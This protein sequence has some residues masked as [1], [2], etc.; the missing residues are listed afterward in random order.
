MTRLYD[1]AEKGD[2]ELV[3]KYLA[4]G[5]DPN[6]VTDILGS[7]EYP[8]CAV[9]QQNRLDDVP[10]KT[11][12]AIA[13]ELID[14][15]AKVDCQTKTGWTPLHWAADMHDADF[16]DFLLRNHAKVDVQSDCLKET[17]LHRAAE[18]NIGGHVDYAKTLKLLLDAGADMNAISSIGMRPVSDILASGREDLINLFRQYG[19]IKKTVTKSERDLNSLLRL[20]SKGGLFGPND[21]PSK[22]DDDD[23]DSEL[24]QEFK[25]KSNLG[26]P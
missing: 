25:K 20:A 26:S 2:L 1:A 11:R 3:K 15:K 5:D 14:H 10:T 4:A 12:L 24:N 22:Y 18:M 23:S 16:V 8:L 7:L 13:Q 19:E 21:D 17:P 6:E 9:V